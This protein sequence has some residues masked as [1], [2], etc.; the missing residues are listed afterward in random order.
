[1]KYIQSISTLVFV[2]HGV[3][4]STELPYNWWMIIW[5]PSLCQC[6]KTKKSWMIV[7]NLLW[8]RCQKKSDCCP[9]LS[10]WVFWKGT[11]Q[12]CH[13]WII[14]EVFPKS[15][16]LSPLQLRTWLYKVGWFRSWSTLEIRAGPSGVLLVVASN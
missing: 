14:V 8:Q 11:Y 13:I 3:S 2:P 15:D 5:N 6:F 10:F 16:S 9:I 12:T 1:M 4:L 7:F